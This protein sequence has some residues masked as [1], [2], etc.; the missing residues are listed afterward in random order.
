MAGPSYAWHLV[1]LYERQDAERKTRFIVP[2]TIVNQHAFQ[3]I[4][5]NS[6]LSCPFSAQ[7]LSCMKLGQMQG[8]ALVKLAVSLTSSIK[9][10]APEDLSNHLKCSADNAEAVPPKVLSYL[11]HPLSLLVLAQHITVHFHLRWFILIASLAFPLDANS[12]DTSRAL[13]LLHPSSRK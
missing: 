10:D 11:R 13:Y 6:T 12:T 9:S 5:D 4:G 1:S 2:L 3:L 7:Q 8:R